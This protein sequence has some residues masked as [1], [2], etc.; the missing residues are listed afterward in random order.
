MKEE[1]ATPGISLEAFR[2]GDDMVFEQVKE[3]YHL[4]FFDFANQLVQDDDAAKDIVS[5]TFEKLKRKRNDLYTLPNLKCFM[6]ITVR[7]S[8]LDYLRM[9]NMALKKQQND[10]K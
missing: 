8:C 6:Y 9:M 3:I 10:Q 2:A 4:T 5:D 7:N 1:P